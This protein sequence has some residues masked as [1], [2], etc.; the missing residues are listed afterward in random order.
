MNDVIK[1]QPAPAANACRPVWEN[2]VDDMRARDE[3]GR[4]R[5]GMPLQPFNGRDALVDAY[6]EALDLAVYLRQAIAENGA[7]VPAIP[8]RAAL[9]E[10]VARLRKREEELLEANARLTEE[11]RAASIR[12]HVVAFHLTSTV[13]PVYYIPKVPS[14]ERVRFRAKLVAEEFVELI[15]ALFDE[16]RVESWHIKRLKSELNYIVDQCPVR[17]DIVEAADAFADLDYVVEGSRLEFG[18]NGV[19]IAV[20]VQRSN[21]AKFVGGVANLS[22]H[23]VIKPAG[24]APPNVYGKLVEQG[25]DP[26]GYV[27][28]KAA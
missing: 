22:G 1:D 19:P 4:E 23:K 5:Y 11:K 18:I 15:E 7:E 27:A 8:H 28:K 26:R 9:A 24:W 21:M 14:E 16:S 6:Q 10:E 2:V 3:I 12:E 17:V 20:E 13:L 25:W